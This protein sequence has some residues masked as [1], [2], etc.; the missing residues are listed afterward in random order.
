[1]SYHNGGLNYG[2]L[3]RELERLS[4]C[5]VIRFDFGYF[6]PNGW[7]SYRGYYEDLAIGYSDNISGGHDEFTVKD[8]LNILA[9]AKAGTLYGHKGG[10]YKVKD[11]TSVWVSKDSSQC[12]GTYIKS[13]QDYSLGF[14][15]INTDYEHL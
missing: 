13:I 15:I 1:M 9:E 8:L 2:Q 7:H 10:E 3:V 11:A 14:A 12:T 6:I 4:T 5:S